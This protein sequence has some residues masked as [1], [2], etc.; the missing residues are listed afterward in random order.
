MLYWCCFEYFDCYFRRGRDRV[1]VGFTTTYSI[2]A[3]HHQSCKFQSHSVMV[4]CTRYN[5]I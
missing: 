5:I 3:Y 4:R 2:N 1:V